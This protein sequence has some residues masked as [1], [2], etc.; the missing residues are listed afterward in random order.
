M[1]I[2]WTL[3]TYL[4]I[5]IFILA[6]FSSGWWKEALVTFF[7]GLLV[8]LLQNPDWA[9]TFVDFLNGIIASLWQ[10]LP[11]AWQT[12]LANALALDISSGAPQFNPGN[13]GTWLVILVVGL[14]IVTQIGRLALPRSYLLSPM[15]RLLGAALAGVNGFLV[16]NLV[17]EYLDGRSL[18]GTTAAVSN[19]GI[20]VVGGGAGPSVR[21]PAG[22]VSIQAANMPGFTLLDSA[23]PWII[24]GIGL[25]LL[26]LVILNSVTIETNEEKMRRISRRRPFGYR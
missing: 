21:A 4:V 11:P 18:P 12:N 14:L 5:G 24:A 7:L 19:A 20:T 15:G 6:G 22:S 8:L 10:L 2:N 13:A 25:V 23:A 9:Q 16:V 26:V 3:M 17:R 1:E